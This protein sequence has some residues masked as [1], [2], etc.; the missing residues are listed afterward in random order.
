MIFTQFSGGTIEKHPSF[1]T[2]TE[3]LVWLD[4]N[5]PSS[6][7]FH[8]ED[9]NPPKYAEKTIPATNSKTITA[10]DIALSNVDFN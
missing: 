9:S 8:I 3:R 5:Q 10:V 7:S 4:K 2:N 1:E 6:V